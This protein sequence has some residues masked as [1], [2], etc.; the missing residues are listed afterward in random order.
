MNEKYLFD[1][2][3]VMLF[4][5][6]FRDNLSRYLLHRIFIKLFIVYPLPVWLEHQ[7]SIVL[8]SLQIKSMTLPVAWTNPIGLRPFCCLLNMK[9]VLSDDPVAIIDKSGDCLTAVTRSPCGRRAWRRIMQGLKKV[10][11]MMFWTRSLIG[12]RSICWRHLVHTVWIIPI[13][14]PTSYW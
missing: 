3:W 10:L 5:R 2:N 9:I 12:W 1:Q 11:K 14:K 4:D 7:A 13:R 8:S 6:L